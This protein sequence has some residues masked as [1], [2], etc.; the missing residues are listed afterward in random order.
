M[1]PFFLFLSVTF[2]LFAGAGYAFADESADENTLREITYA[3]GNPDPAKGE[4]AFIRYFHQTDEKN[5][6][7]ITLSKYS[8]IAETERVWKS[9]STDYKN[10]GTNASFGGSSVSADEQAAQAASE[11]RF[12]DAETGGANANRTDD[13]LMVYKIDVPFDKSAVDKAGI[14]GYDDRD[15]LFV[16]PEVKTETSESVQLSDGGTY[17]ILVFEKKAF[18]NSQN[19]SIILFGGSYAKSAE[20]ED[21]STSPYAIPLAILFLAIGCGIVLAMFTTTG[22]KMDD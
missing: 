21:Y 9:F 14:A 3:F 8:S 2:F 1:S 17:S 15:T 6:L 10:S 7:T 18:A 22:A 19:R 20:E 11:S 12:A 5:V 13:E 16:F 4:D